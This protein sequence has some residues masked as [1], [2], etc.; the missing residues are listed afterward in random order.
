VPDV[1]LHRIDRTLDVEAG[2]AAAAIAV[3]PPSCVGTEGVAPDRLR[4]TANQ[5]GTA[6]FAGEV[7]TVRRLG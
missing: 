2:T 7:T 6:V 4:D 3:D 5:V 1:G